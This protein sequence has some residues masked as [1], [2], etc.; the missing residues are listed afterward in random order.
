M[1]LL[2]DL[3]TPLHD[4]SYTDRKA[5]DPFLSGRSRTA[6]R[7]GLEEPGLGET[8]LRI[9][10]ALESGPATRRELAERTGKTKSAI[11]RATRRAEVLA[12]IDVDLDDETGAK[13]YGLAGYTWDSVETLRPTLKTFK[14]GAEREDRALEHAQIGVERLRAYHRN[15]VWGDP[16][17]LAK[18]NRRH[19][20]ITN[21]RTQLVRTIYPSWDDDQVAQ[22]IFA[23]RPLSHDPTSGRRLD[24]AGSAGPPGGPGQDLSDQGIGYEEALIMAEYAGWD[25]NDIVRAY[26]LADD[27]RDERTSSRRQTVT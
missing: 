25:R 23:D 8:I 22:W 7:L 19:M 20:R 18:L 4:A 14:L 27:M 24:R 2:Y 12:L 9:F 3:R 5:D 26:D 1:T 16:D 15:K 17:E 6:K 21:K 13:V 10:D 11:Q